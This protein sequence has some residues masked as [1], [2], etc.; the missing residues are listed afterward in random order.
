M[1]IIS[2]DYLRNLTRTAATMFARWSQENFF[3]YMREN[4]S[5]D[6]L[7][8]YSTENIPESTRIVGREFREKEIGARP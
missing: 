1:S 8:D 6:A 7:V 4:Y 5:I 2:T 3:K